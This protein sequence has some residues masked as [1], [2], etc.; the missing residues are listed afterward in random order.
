MLLFY[1][2][3]QCYVQHEMQQLL[4]KNE[5]RLEKLIVPLADFQRNKICD[6]EILLN[7]KM[8]DIK[9][10]KISVDHVELLALNDEKEEIILETIKMLVNGN[11][12]HNKIPQHIISFISLVFLAPVDDHQI[13]KIDLPFNYFYPVSENII[14]RQSEIF[15]PPPEL[16]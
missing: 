8:Y 3:Q 15:S 2:M 14:S 9:S 5:S 12:T 13:Y 1:L 11:T 6:N 7:G 10:I 16:V 4:N